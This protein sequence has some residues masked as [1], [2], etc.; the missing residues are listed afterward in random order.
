MAACRHD[1]SACGGAERVFRRARS[2][3]ATPG[4]REPGS[5]GRDNRR[6]RGI[7]ETLSVRRRS[8]RSARTHDSSLPAPA[9]QLSSTRRLDRRCKKRLFAEM[10]CADRPR[11][12]HLL[13]HYGL[14]TAPV[15]ARPSASC[16]ADAQLEQDMGR[17][18][19]SA[20]TCCWLQPQLPRSWPIGRGAGSSCCAYGAGAGTAAARQH[21]VRRIYG[22]MTVVAFATVFLGVLFWQ[23]ASVL[24][25][26]VGSR[27]GRRRTPEPLSPRRAAISGRRSPPA[28]ELAGGALV[29]RS[30]RA[31]GGGMLPRA[32][33]PVEIE[34]GDEVT[35][36]QQLAS[37]TVR[38]V[39]AA[40]A[41]SSDA[42]RGA[43]GAIRPRAVELVADIRPLLEAEAVAQRSG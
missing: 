18:V 31:E 1:T 42:G 26:A 33:A 5:P 27:A 34:H 11:L 35:P 9:G 43:S 32:A 22:I 36:P 23:L 14:R 19:A 2:P 3:A 25:G 13:G 17:L 20:M 41:R 28:A 12:V 38:S 16:S 4:A 15:T 29:K 39:R 6:S 7:V 10:L 40:R 21:R 24:V 37:A 8:R 30:R